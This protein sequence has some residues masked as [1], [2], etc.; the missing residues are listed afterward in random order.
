MLQILLKEL[1]TIAVS[2]DMMAD[3]MASVVITGP[4]KTTGKDEQASPRSAPCPD[5]HLTS[6][7]SRLLLACTPACL[8]PS[9][10]SWV[11]GRGCP[12][13]SR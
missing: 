9:G 13:C 1:Q 3:A 4:T 10:C 5:N 7:Y 6:A 8:M 2:P 11:T 12:R